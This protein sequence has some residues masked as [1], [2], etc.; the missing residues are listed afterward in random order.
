MYKISKAKLWRDADNCKIVEASVIY[1]DIEFNACVEEY[2]DCTRYYHKINGKELEGESNKN[3]ITE[4]MMKWAN[5]EVSD[6]V[7]HMKERNV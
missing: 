7:K 1:G 2:F 6:F 3:N 5:K 4:N